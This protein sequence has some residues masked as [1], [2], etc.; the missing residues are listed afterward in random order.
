MPPKKTTKGAS[1]KGAEGD[2]P[3][4]PEDQIL[5]LQANLE[6]VKHKLV[7]QTN[8][9]SGAEATVRE[10]RQQLLD[11]QA[12]YEN[13]KKNTFDIVSD[14]TREYKT[15]KDEMLKK[16]V[17]LEAINTR[18]KDELA[19]AEMDLVNKVADKDAEIGVKEKQR[20]EI[21][22]RMDDMAQEFGA[23]LK[24]TLDKMSEKIVIT[25]DYDLDKQDAPV[26]RT[27]ED[28]NLGPGYSAGS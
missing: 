26:V 4:Q 1:K 15:M 6:S 14:M 23:M 18:Y 13:E 8:K 28:F 12:I 2:A 25:N 21:K 5:Y 10:L 24:Q 3:L 27:F 11:L 7:M 20:Q 19:K 17:D 22:T 16:I 9:A